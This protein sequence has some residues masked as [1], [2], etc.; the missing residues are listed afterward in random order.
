MLTNEKTQTPSHTST[1]IAIS[2]SRFNPIFEAHEERLSDSQIP[3]VNVSRKVSICLPRDHASAK[4]NSKV[5][6]PIFEA[7]EE[8]LSDSQI[9]TVNVSRKMCIRLPR[10][11]ASAKQNSK[12]NEKILVAT[13]PPK[14]SINVHK[15][16]ALSLSDTQLPIGIQIELAAQSLLMYHL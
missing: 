10:D 12:V 16:L 5:N 14:S 2:E 3:T 13:K 15:P 1:G 9:P 11:H 8:R 6:I 4:Q 7:H